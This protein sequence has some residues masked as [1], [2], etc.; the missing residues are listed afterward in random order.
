MDVYENLKLTISFLLS[1]LLIFLNWQ[2]TTANFS[3]KIE[4]KTNNKQIQN[5]YLLV[6]GINPSTGN[7]CFLQVNKDGQASRCVDVGLGTDSTTFSFDYRELK[8][9]TMVLPNIISGRVYIS[10]NK[11]LK[12]PIVKSDT[13]NFGIAHPSPYN[14]TDPSYDL[15]FDKVEFTYIGNNTW[16]NPTAVD[17]FNLPLSIEQNGKN[18]GLTAPR[19][20]IIA[21]VIESFDKAPNKAWQKLIVKNDKGDVLR[22][23]APGRD[24]NYF[25]KNYLTGTP[26]S[27]VDDV[28]D[29]YKTHTLLIDASELK[30]NPA[31][32]RLGDYIFTG[33]VVG[34]NF[35]FTNKSGD[36]TQIIGKPESNPFF[37]G[38]QGEFNAQ[39]NTPRAIIARNLSAAWCVG[40][41]P[42]PTGTLLNR[43]YYLKNQNKFYT[44]NPL[45]SPASKLNGPYYN[46]YGKAI[47]NFSTTVYTFAYDDAFGYDGTNGSTDTYPAML[48]I[49]DMSGVT[50]E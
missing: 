12:M 10:L 41:L 35:I 19:K 20:D 13:G 33:K 4:D 25:D 50:I 46:L 37:L 18:Y 32:P 43:E 38:A 11:K 26:Y 42:A 31:A 47:H 15:F 3:V 23:L 7:Q 30:G 17:F 28:W 6:T 34:N 5:I 39:N 2:T 22:I 1:S 45:L 16:T 36:H 8:N 49:G 29:Y 27:W 21:G 14:S 48:T 44:E 40:L 9:Y 24:N